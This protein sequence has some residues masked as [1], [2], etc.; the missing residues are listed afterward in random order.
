MLRMR[1]SPITANPTSPMSAF[2]I[3]VF[4]LWVLKPGLT[5]DAGRAPLG[6]G[7][8]LSQR[9]HGRIAWEGREQGTM[10]PPQFHGLFGGGPGEQA[11]DEAAGEPVAAA[12][13]VD[14]LQLG[15]GRQMGL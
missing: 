8:N 6:E 5:L 15:R 11:I 7:P 10:C 1:F 14:H 4:V 9:G 12:D 3:F 2:S 13:A